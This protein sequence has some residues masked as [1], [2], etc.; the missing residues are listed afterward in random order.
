MGNFIRE[1]WLDALGMEKPRPS[2]SSPPICA[3]C[4][5]AGLGGDSTVPFAFS[6]F[7][8]DPL[9]NVRRITDAFVDFSQVTEEDWYAN[10][11]TPEMLPGAREGFRWLNTLYH[12]GLLPDT[13]A[14][15]DNDQ[16]NDTMLIMG[17]NGTF[18]SNL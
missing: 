10:A 5:E 12:E 14:L 7:E 8:S 3:R 16:A 13:F 18:P 17:Y 15:T 1:D 2:M 6:I 11:R 4:K 9:F